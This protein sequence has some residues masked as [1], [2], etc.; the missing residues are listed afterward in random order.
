M[1]QPGVGLGRK[2]R[3][4]E[5]TFRG[6]SSPVHLQQST[7]PVP[8]AC[9]SCPARCP[10]SG[11]GALVHRRPM[12]LVSATREYRRLLRGDHAMQSILGGVKLEIRGELI[13][14]VRGEERGGFARGA[15]AV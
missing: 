11:T 9:L 13:V 6:T 15:H 7:D 5:T 2:C 1:E 12:F 10:K 3:G 14:L 8:V 4:G